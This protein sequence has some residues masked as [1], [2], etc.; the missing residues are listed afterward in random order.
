MPSSDVM[1]SVV[2]LTK[3]ID[4]FSRAQSVT[5][6]A[7]GGRAPSGPAGGTSA[8]P[9]LLAAI[10]VGV[11]L[12]RGRDGKGEGRGGGKGKAR[13]TDREGKRR[14]KG[15]GKGYTERRVR[16]EDCHCLLFV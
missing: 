14:E 15:R 7:F 2:G 11:L 10:G 5:I 9:D 13:E 1:L 12:L 4:A 3:L 8:L 6:N 16:G